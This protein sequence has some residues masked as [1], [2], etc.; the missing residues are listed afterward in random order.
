MNRFVP[1]LSLGGEFT[2]ADTRK[3]P[4]GQRGASVSEWQ[5]KELSPQ[6]FTICIVTL[7]LLKRQKPETERFAAHGCRLKLFQVSV[8]NGSP[9]TAGIPDTPASQAAVHKCELAS[10]IAGSGSTPGPLSHWQKKNMSELLI[11]Q[12]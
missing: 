9:K 5:S 3:R 4:T 1:T 6:E 12:F 11:W 7:K 10:R 2:R 8:S